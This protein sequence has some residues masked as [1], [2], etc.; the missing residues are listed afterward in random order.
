MR[1]VHI[2][3]KGVREEVNT[4]FLIDNDNS[5]DL[6]KRNKGNMSIC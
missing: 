4:N 3:W 1:Y 5:G 2:V 6:S